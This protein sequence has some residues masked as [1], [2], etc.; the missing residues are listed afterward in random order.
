MAW[1]WSVLIGVWCSL[2][3][4]LTGCAPSAPRG[5]TASADV[6]YA[7]SRAIPRNTTAL[8]A[9][10][11]LL[12]GDII[13]V[14]GSEGE[15]ALDAFATGN[16]P[17]RETA[18]ILADKGVAINNADNGI[19]IRRAEGLNGQE[20]AALTKDWLHVRVPPDRD[21]PPISVGTGNIE[22]YGRVGKVTA[23]I[24]E[25]GDIRVRGAN[26]DVNLTTQK[27]SIIA[28]IMAGH[29]IKANAK[30]GN[31]DICAVGAFVTASTTNGWVRFIG[32]LQGGQTHTFSTT[33]AGSI[34]IALPAYPKDH[35]KGQVYRVTAT[36]T[37][38]PISTEYPAYRYQSGDSLPICGFIY[39]SGPY[40]YH[41][42]NTTAKTG[43]IEVSP[44]LTLNV[45]LYRHA[46]RYLLPVR[47][48]SDLRVFLH[49]GA[50]EHS[51]LH[52]GAIESD[53]C[54]QRVD[55]ARVSGRAG[56]LVVKRRHREFENRPRPHSHSA[57]SHAGRWRP[58]KTACYRRPFFVN[59][60]RLPAAPPPVPR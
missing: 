59:Q 56:C 35:P 20:V 38:S 1:H 9:I 25:T 39:G 30:E 29:A 45:F 12:N 40:D 58:I 18:R 36:T 21:L 14:T 49:P 47:Y 44:A 27:G 54:R 41:V 37:G 22:V 8:P 31:L 19:S 13:V 33:G 10:S 32:T 34:Q 4:A 50:A 28:D 6:L 7:F 51:H 11:N 60:G 46:G 48:Q 26:G 2:A 23:V 57:H 42:E 3:L 53:H 15:V 17:S 55:C 43:R 52:I 24:S 16:G 5:G